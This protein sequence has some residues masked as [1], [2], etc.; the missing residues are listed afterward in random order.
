MPLSPSFDTVGW[1]A[2]DGGL[3]ERVGKVLLGE[4]DA[5]GQPIRRLLLLDDAFELL[6]PEVRAPLERAAEELAATI[7][8]I[9]RTTLSSEGYADWLACFNAL[10][11][12]EIWAIYGDW[13]TRTQPRFGPEI[14]ARFEAVKRTAH[15]DTTARCARAAIQEKRRE[16]LR[17]ERFP[18]H[19]PNDAPL[20]GTPAAAT[21]APRKH[22][23]FDV[24]LTVIGNARGLCR[25]RPQT[26]A[27]SASLVGPTGGDAS[28]RGGTTNPRRG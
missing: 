4:N 16:C 6:D 18:A 5:G 8:P 13:I 28:L 24:H 1:F 12:P 27:R 20:K 17:R 22:V 10:R 15:A 14:A 23:S 26:V 2:R 7:A 3:L 21:Q 19:C 25:W 11:P 9:S